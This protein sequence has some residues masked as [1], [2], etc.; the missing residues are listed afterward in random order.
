MVAAWAL[1][2][3]A[4]GRPLT[5]HALVVPDPEGGVDGERAA[6][7]VERLL[8]SSERYDTLD[9]SLLEARTGESAAAAYGRCRLQEGCWRQ[10][11]A[12][13]GVEQVVLVERVDND[14]LGVRV[15][16]ASE[17]GGVRLG[18]TAFDQGGAQLVDRLFLQPGRLE[19]G[20]LPIGAAVMVD[21]HAVPTPA[22]TRAVQLDPLAAGK[23]V[24]EVDA[25]GHAGLFVSVMVYPDQWTWVSADLAVVEA[26]TRRVPW[27]PWVGA[28]LAIGGAVALGLN[29]GDG[30]QF[31]AP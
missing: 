21:G 17:R 10:V 6:E 29:A 19:V 12:R 5:V 22:G 16:D 11:A 13:A 30:G 18:T 15:V 3:P 20:N 27:G 24:V 31:A 4:W 28:A 26:E 23:H 8:R 1:S 7:I 25:P 9:H 14:V 2:A